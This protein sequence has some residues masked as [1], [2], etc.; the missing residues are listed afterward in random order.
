MMQH[1][2]TLKLDISTTN[3]LRGLSILIIVI[4]HIV[5]YYGF[6]PLFNLPGSVAVAVFLFLSGY[7]VNESWKKRGL[8]HFW[9]KK[10]RR[11]IL[12]YYLLLLV[13][14]AITG[15]FSWHDFLLDI[16]FIHSSYWFIEYVV[17]CYFVFW[18]VRKFFPRHTSVV[19]ILFGLLSP[20]FRNLTNSLRALRSKPPRM[21]FLLFK[22][23]FCHVLT[24]MIV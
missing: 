15:Q 5:L 21:R 7:G 17:R 18:L 6:S 23:A 20:Q 24:D 8:R 13:K 12:P 1:S 14:A 19:F 9:L 16:T 22:L 3:V 11:I 10:L 4:F 2:E